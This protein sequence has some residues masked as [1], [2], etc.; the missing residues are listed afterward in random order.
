MGFH[1]EMTARMKKFDLELHPEKTRLIQFG[2]YA[3][4]K[5]GKERKKPET[6]K[7]LG[8]VHACG[9]KRTGGFEVVRST[10]PKKR[11]AKTR[12]IKDELR[13]RMHD[14]V[15]DVGTWLGA[16][17]TGHYNYYGVPGNSSA[18]WQFRRDI[19]A[20]WF[21]TLRRRSQ[22]HTLTWEKMNRWIERFLP[23][24][25]IT[26]PYPRMRFRVTTRGRSLVR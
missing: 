6:F 23:P 5:G 17:L 9:R 12:E 1:E 14:K 10:D 2:R 21:R 24:A 26:H 20:R 3:S 8:F 19:G 18:L 16:V 25:Q 4:E 22:K 7:F 15:H 13:K 11:Q